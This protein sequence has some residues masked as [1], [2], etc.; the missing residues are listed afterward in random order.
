VA[1]LDGHTRVNAK[2]IAVMG[3]SHGGS[4]AIWA[5]RAD[6]AGD[7][8]ADRLEAVIAFYP[9]C[10][11]TPVALRSQV[12]VFIGEADTWS[13]V[14]ACREMERRFRA[15]GLDARAVVYP[16]ATHAFDVSGP[17]RVALGRHRMSLDPVAAADA[18]GRVD[19]ILA[20]YLPPR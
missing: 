5:A 11:T 14:S 17:E 4:A 10:P 19:A 1:A 3:F 2:R 16:L 18:T 7:A 13:P 20:R 8:L 6:G 9:L 12:T 15:A